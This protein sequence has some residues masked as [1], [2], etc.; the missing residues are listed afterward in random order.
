MDPEFKYPVYNPCW[1]TIDAA[2]DWGFPHRTHDAAEAL[3]QP[4]SVACVRVFYDRPWIFSYDRSIPATDLGKFDLVVVSDNEYFDLARI[5]DWIANLG[6]KN[7]VLATGGTRPDDVL[8]PQR[9]MYRPYFIRHF[10]ER[11][12]VYHDNQADSKPFLFEALLGAR[13]PHRDYVM[14]AMDQVGLLERSIITYRSGFPGEIIDSM[15]DLVRTQ[16]PDKSLQWPYVSPNLDPSW[17][18]TAN[19]NNSISHHSPVE[20]YRR[21]WYSIIC[22]TLGTGS[23]FFLSEKTIK[24]MFNKRFFVM[25]GPQ[26]FLANLRS[27]GFETF[28]HFINEDFDQEERDTFRYRYAIN[29]V[30]QLAWFEN[31]R[32]IYAGVRP[33]LEH[34]HKRLF[35]IEEARTRQQRE[36]LMKHIPPQHWLY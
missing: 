34:N 5:R 9:E 4:F 22:E 32:E 29:Q 16:F 26:N 25:F 17:E 33:I 21:T 14:L 13:R 27:L 2:S 11:N 35:E 36:L 7:Y 10:L 12:P 1:Q 15:T 31:P 3:A 19:I 18:V 24:A 30:M 28:R 6:V 8:D 20:I 23:S